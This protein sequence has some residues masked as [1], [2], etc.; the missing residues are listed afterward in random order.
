MKT[1]DPTEYGKQI[2]DGEGNLEHT[3][4]TMQGVAGEIGFV[5]FIETMLDCGCNCY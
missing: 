2:N 5:S 3:V 4:E 1:C